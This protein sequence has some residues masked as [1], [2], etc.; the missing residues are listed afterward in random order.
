MN[1][2]VWFTL[3]DVMLPS[4]ISWWNSSKSVKKNRVQMFDSVE[5]SG[6]NSNKPSSEV[7]LPTIFHYIMPPWYSRCEKENSRRIGN[8]G[9]TSVVL[10]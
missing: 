4:C 3:F 5:I 8:Y 10:K 2:F 7:S 6:S 1:L 9:K